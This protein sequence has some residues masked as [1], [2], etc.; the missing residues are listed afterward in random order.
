MLL[1]LSDN[2]TS[3]LA[4]PSSGWSLNGIT[5]DYRDRGKPVKSYTSSDHHDL[6]KDMATEYSDMTVCGRERVRVVV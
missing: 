2:G 6:F 4:R 5:V 3:T 1:P